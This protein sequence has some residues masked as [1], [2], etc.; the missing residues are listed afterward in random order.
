MCTKKILVFRILAII[1]TALIA[2]FIFSQSMLPATSSSAES[3]RVLQFLNG[4][5]E[6]IGLTPFF[7]Q[8]LVR[9]IAHFIEFGV[10][11]IMLCSTL[12]LFK[13][14]MSFSALFALGGTLFVAITDECIQLFS[15]GRSFQIRDILLDTCGGFVF[16][17]VL[18]A[19]MFFVNRKKMKKS[20]CQNQKS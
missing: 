14:K 6:N 2:A 15:A 12:N 11:G 10:F 20:L 16:I 3:G 13:I 4:I 9:K 19:I 1:S 8:G 7:T 5:L 18:T 17:S